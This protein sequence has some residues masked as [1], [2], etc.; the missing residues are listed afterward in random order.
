MNEETKRKKRMSPEQFE[1]ML[2]KFPD[3]RQAYAELTPMLPNDMPYWSRFELSRYHSAMMSVMESEI[4]T[5]EDKLEKGQ[6][7]SDNNEADL[8]Y[9]NRRIRNLEVV[10]RLLTTIVAGL[11]L[12]LGL[13]AL[14]IMFPSWSL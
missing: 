2:Q 11:V 6:M 13:G 1:D 7:R 12:L 4:V 8:E 10:C 5:L 9:A 3:I 14:I